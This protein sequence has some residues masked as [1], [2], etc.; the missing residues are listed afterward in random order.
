MT[1]PQRRPE[2]SIAKDKASAKAQRRPEI[3]IA[4]DKASA[5]ATD[6]K[7]ASKNQTKDESET[8]TLTK[9]GMA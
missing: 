1:E 3:S 9:L 7:C 8:H 6:T 5:K 4:K 2:I